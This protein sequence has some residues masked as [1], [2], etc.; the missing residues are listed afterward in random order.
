MKRFLNVLIILG[1][2]ALAVSAQT[3]TDI[4]S[5]FIQSKGFTF[6]GGVTNCSGVCVNRLNGDVVI[7]IIDNGMWRSTDQ[8]GHWARIDSSTVGG[9]CETGW[10]VQ[11]D[12]DNPIRM[13]VFSLDGTAGYTADGTT[14]KKMAG[15][16]RNWDFGSVDWTTADAKVM[17]ATHHESS[18]EVYK[19]TDGAATWIK[20][21]ITVVAS[22]GG[23]TPTAMVGVIN[24]N[25]FIYS[26]GSGINR[27]TD[28]GATWNNVSNANPQT[29]TVTVFKNVCYLGTTTGLL[30]STDQGATWQ[31][32]GA[33]VN[34]WQG[35]FF[36]ADENTMVV[37]GAQGVYKTT[38][39]GTAWNKIVSLPGAICTGNTF[40]PS[41]YAML[42]WDP[43]NN[44][45]YATRMVCPA[46]KYPLSPSAVISAAHENHSGS[47]SSA[48]VR[49]CRT[50]GDRLIIKDIASAGAVD[51]YNVLG[52]FLGS[53]PVKSDGTVVVGRNISE[54]QIVFVRA[55]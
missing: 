8:G 46:F 38:N 47:T 12:Q 36:G 55:R 42:T 34:I 44:D 10:A 35:P 23:S 2:L 26:T 48:R 31:T 53:V 9:R 16:G 18:G 28:Q 21:P 7:K 51:V 13:A 54:Q 50:S 5:T 20:L 32:R 17:I 1:S 4:S 3:W 52:Y 19:T 6:P 22:G 43:V 27:S 15:M 29:R 37:V 25:T 24:T 49:A 14:W 30:V 11:V 39:A 41:W 40:D 33:T 45:V